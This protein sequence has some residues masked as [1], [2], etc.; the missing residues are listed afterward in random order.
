[1]RARPKGF[2]RT[3]A[4]PRIQ[5]SAGR[6][7]R[8][9]SLRAAVRRTR[10]EPYWTP[11]PESRQSAQTPSSRAS[12]RR[13][14]PSEVRGEDRAA[15]RSAGIGVEGRRG[16]RPRWLGARGRARS[17]DAAGDASIR[18]HSCLVRRRGRTT[19]LVRASPHP[20]SSS[21]GSAF[22]AFA[23]FRLFP[24]PGF[25]V[26]SDSLADPVRLH[27]QLLDAPQRVSARH[28]QHPFQTLTEPVEPRPLRRLEALRCKLAAR[29]HPRAHSED[30]LLRVEHLAAVVLL[31][32]LLQ[33]P[34]GAR[35]SAVRASR[36]R[37]SSP[38]RPETEARSRPGPMPR[39]PLP[40]RAVS[41]RSA[42]GARASSLAGAH[43]PRAASRRQG[44]RP[45]AVGV[46]HLDEEGR[47]VAAP[48]G[49][50]R[51]AAT[52]ATVAGTTFC[53]QA[54]TA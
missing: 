29:P 16:L 1:M 46:D 9:S 44:V 2:V 33:V 7:C 19:D 34:P 41:S 25:N 13:P 12:I 31:Q 52:E 6:N 24:L 27:P 11:S 22:L 26:V 4:R 38:R 39:R 36:S 32:A 3:R 42:Q 28:R 8:T 47:H 14:V 23:P 43:A 37:R 17:P 50:Q 40:R 53:G 54:P 5:P 51:D 30:A 48:R 18:K 21:F 45:R 15:S 49:I 35:R 20:T 10:S